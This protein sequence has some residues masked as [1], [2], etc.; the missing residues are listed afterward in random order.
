MVSAFSPQFRGGRSDRICE[1]KPLQHA[2]ARQAAFAVGD[3][4]QPTDAAQQAVLIGVEGAIGIR[5]LPEHL[6]EFDALLVGQP[7]VDDAGEM[8]QF[9][10]TI[11]RA[12][13]RRQQ[14]PRI[15]LRQIEPPLE[16]FCHDGALP[17][18]KMVVAVR[19]LGKQRR[20]CQ[21]QLV[22]AFARVVGGTGQP[23]Y[24]AVDH[25]LLPNIG[26][27]RAATP[28]GLGF[29]RRRIRRRSRKR[30]RGPAVLAAD[31]AKE[32]PWQDAAPSLFSILS[33]GCRWPGSP[34]RRC[35]TSSGCS[36]WVTT[37]GTSKTAAPTPMIR[38]SPASSWSAITT[39]PIC[40]GGWRPTVLTAAGRIGTRSTTPGMGSPAS[41][42]RGSIAK[43][44]P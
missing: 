30:S 7:F 31:I 24:D 5:H 32:R 22:L 44:T 15:G 3:I 11:G 28:R 39:S 16:K 9:G 43:P 23:S 20:Q 42:S 21:L 1:P 34:G 33:D 41:G 25:C 26:D 13:T 12:L 35:I 38:A 29:W 10:R 17:L 8:E 36:G 18:V 6:D 40:G 27:R 19:H 4:D 2:L 14:R 37:S